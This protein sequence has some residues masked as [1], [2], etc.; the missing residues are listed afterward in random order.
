M[1]APRK[2]LLRNG[3]RYVVDSVN[4]K[5]SIAVVGNTTKKFAPLTV[6]TA[7]VPALGMCL[8]KTAF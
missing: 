6:L 8:S 3:P 1:V 5:I 2:R 4:G 7:P